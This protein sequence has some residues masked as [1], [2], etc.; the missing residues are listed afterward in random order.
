MG[1]SNI[2]GGDKPL[3]DIENMAAE[4]TDLYSTSS[5]RIDRYAQYRNENEEIRNPDMEFAIRDLSDYGRRP[6]GG[7]DAARHRIPL[8]LGIAQTVKHTFRVS[9]QLPDLV[10][11]ERD[12][13]PG[14]RYR[15]DSM[16]KI[17]WA[18][19]RE[20][21]SETLFSS[22]GWDGSQLGTTVFEVEMDLG[23]NMPIIR[24]VEPGGFI[25]VLG[26]KNPHDFSRVYRVWNV[27]LRSLAQDYRG[28][29]FR[30]EA[31]KVGDFRATNASLDT[32]EMIRVVKMTDKERTIMFAYG[33][34][35]VVGLEEF[36]HNYGFV[37][38]V[39]IPNIGKYEEVFGWSDYE[40]VRSLIHYLSALLSRQADV[41]RSVANGAMIERGTGQSPEAIKKAIA[42]GGVIPS[43][44]EG[45]IEPIQA[46]DMPSFATEH[47]ATVMQLFKMVGFTP[48]AAWGEPGSQSGQDR[49]LQLQPL[50]EY[51]A[52]KQMNWGRG[53]TRL[54]EMTFKMI[55]SKMVGQSTYSGTRPAGSSGKQSAFS[56][57]FGPNSEAIKQASDE[58]DDL[59]GEP[60]MLSFPR[61]P[62]ELFAGYYCMRFVWRNRLDPDDPSYVT[63]ELSKFS[64]GVQSLKTTLE[65]LGAEAPE[66]EM[67]RIEQEAERF[68]WINQGMIALLKAQTAG[69]GAGG[70]N[71][72]DPLA[73]QNMDALGTMN[74]PNSGMGNDASAQMGAMPGATPSQP[75]YGG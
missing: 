26:A 24:S 9:G 64:Q 47:Q 74:D 75:Q 71:P 33:Q 40:L 57:T 4:F 15:S 49:G 16:E 51:T 41:I 22:G 10:V 8:P 25:P 20:S 72:G 44:K 1:L 39:A 37:N 27:P 53:L 60:V 19:I 28:K 58:V 63:S 61:T 59:T 52:M 29:M 23:K 32:V 14:E 12:T 67:R 66:D 54:F 17:G 45:A 70:G 21:G 30:G 7:S 65:R 2:L 36:I 55:E 56:F 69:Q 38:Y 68:P 34:D 3:T 42:T 73:Q 43:R 46:P 50:L 11:D 35:S 62:K 13:S 31:V 48:D 5:A 6:N 18:V